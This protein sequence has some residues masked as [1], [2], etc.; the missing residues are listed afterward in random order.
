MDVLIVGGG[1]A[2][3]MAAAALARFLPPTDMVKLIESDEIGTVGVGEATIPQIRLFNQ[4]LGLDEDELI[5]A[6]KGTIKLGIEFVDWTGPGSRYLHAFG[7]IGRGIGLVSFHHLWLR[8]REAGGTAG[9]WDFSTSACAARANRFAPDLGRP[10]LPSGLAWAFQFDATLYAAHLR[11]YAEQRGVERIEGRVVDVTLDG[12]RGTISSVTLDTGREVGADLFIDCSGFRSILLGGALGEAFDDW[13]DWLPCD[14]AW[15]VPSANTGPL[16]PYTRAT[17]RTAGWQWRI[18]L[19]HRTGNGLVY[20]SAHQSDEAA[21]DLLLAGLDGPPLTDPRPLR[22]TAGRRRNAWVKNCVALGLASGFLEPLEST[23]IHLVQS[24][25]AR[26]LQFLPGTNV[27]DADADEFNRQTEREWTAVRD[28]LVLH[29]HLNRRREPFWAERRAAPLPGELAHRLALFR[30]NGRLAPRAD[31]LFT[32]VAWL[33][34][35]L[36]QGVVPAGYH[37]LADAM[38]AAQLDEWLTLARQHAAAL[39][40]RMPPHDQYLAARIDR[41]GESV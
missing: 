11:R 9:L 34:V 31:E 27:A 26:L 41:L 22:F 20:S 23:S 17:A 33:Q 14:R 28:F 7:T 36:G 40:D 3:W 13:R 2:G 4:H 32:D 38:P 19:R 12:E 30:A 5:R 16:T 21:A 24:G 37:P 8:H 10:E 18:P 39:V 25:I 1:T 15:A 35:M 29:Y 6:T